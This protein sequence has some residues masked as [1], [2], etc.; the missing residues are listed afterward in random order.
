MNT[1]NNAAGRRVIDPM[2][3][4]LRGCE[5]RKY[6]DG[7]VVAIGAPA[8]RDLLSSP[9]LIAVHRYRDAQD[10]TGPEVLKHAKAGI[11]WVCNSV[12]AASG[13]LCSLHAAGAPA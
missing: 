12:A 4:M 9:R 6:R 2:R 7:S 13:V 8:P 1:E 10:F 11:V 5:V 3:E